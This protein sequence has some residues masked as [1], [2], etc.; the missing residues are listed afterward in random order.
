[1][2]DSIKNNQETEG[3]KEENARLKKDLDA[4]MKRETRRTMEEQGMSIITRSGYQLPH[5]LISK[6]KL[7]YMFDHLEDENTK[8]VLRDDELVVLD[9]EGRMKEDPDGIRVITFDALVKAHADVIFTKGHA[10]SAASNGKPA[11]GEWPKEQYSFELPEF[12]NPDE[13]FR[14]INNAPTKEKAKA[15]RDLYP[16]LKANGFF[17]SKEDPRHEAL[18]QK[19]LDDLYGKL[20]GEGLTVEDKKTARD[21]FNAKWV[22]KE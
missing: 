10:A 17:G 3:L 7:K 18:K 1:M 11:P 9:A 16:K 22:A 14:S 5:E 12:K 2:D 19:A 20:Q 13:Y 15:L 8:I 21:E 4:L 6:G